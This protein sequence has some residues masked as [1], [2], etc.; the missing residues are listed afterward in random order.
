MSYEDL[1]WEIHYAIESAGLQKEFDAQLTKMRSQDKHKFK[2]TRA[3]WQ[4]ASTKVINLQKEK[5][6]RNAT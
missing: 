2:D 3:R 5:T 6:K 1:W 4:Y